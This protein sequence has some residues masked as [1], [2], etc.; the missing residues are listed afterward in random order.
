MTSTWRGT[1]S[2]LFWGVLASVA[3]AH[4][5]ENVA[6]EKQARLYSSGPV[7]EDVV[8]EMTG[9]NSPRLWSALPAVP[10]IAGPL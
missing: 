8:R 5:L 1:A 2:V 10:C 4:L 9:R 7:P 3:P 6:G